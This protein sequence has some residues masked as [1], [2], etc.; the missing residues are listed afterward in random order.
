MK[1]IALGSG[2]S[3]GVPIIGCECP[4]CNSED[5]RDHRL[6]SSV[7]VEVDGVDILID[8]GPDFRQQFL[9]SRLNTVDLILI[10]HEHNDHIIG[11]DDIRAINF[12]QKKSIPLFAE[13]RVADEIR[14][15]FEYAFSDTPYP[16]VPRIDIQIIDEDRF[17]TQGISIQPIRLIHGKLPILGFRI[18]DFAY[19]TDANI[20]PEEEL[21]KLEN[22]DVLIINAL[23]KESHYSHFTLDE[24]VR[25]INIINPKRAYI[26]HISHTMGKYD[27][28]ANQLPAHIRPLEDMME[29]KL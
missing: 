18:R 22:L 12:T 4:V 7:A 19:L 15:R 11:L 27:E 3:Q 14:H 10:T 20:I 8:I 5:P 21:H 16:G 24:A 1:V 25:Q 13:K 28:W 23:R 9:R 2:T 6:R 26:T 29:I 17:E